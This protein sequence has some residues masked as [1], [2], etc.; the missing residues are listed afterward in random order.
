MSQ[1]LELAGAYARTEKGN[2]D[3]YYGGGDIGYV[4]AAAACA[5]VPLAIRPGK[6]IGIIEGNKVVEYIWH[7]S[8]VSNTGLVKKTADVDLTAI[9]NRIDAVEAGAPFGGMNPGNINDLNQIGLNKVGGIYRLDFGSTQIVNAPL[10]TYSLQV[11]QAGNSGRGLR[12]MAGYIY[13]QFFLQRA[14]TESGGW[15]PAVEIYHTGNLPAVIGPL[16]GAI[17]GRL[18][19][20]QVD[21]KIS[22]YDLLL[23]DGVPAEGNSMQKLYNAV[24]A[25]LVEKQFNTIALRNAYNVPRLPFQAFVS[26]DGDG[27]WAVYRATTTGV[28]ATYIKTSDPD[29]LNAAL[30]ASAIKAAYESNPDTYAFTN[31]L[32]TKLNA[33]AVGATANT[34]ATDA[35][36]QITAAVSEDNKHVTRLKLFNWWTWIKAQAATIGGVWNFTGGLKVNGADVL[37]TLSGDISTKLNNGDNTS[38][39]GDEGGIPLLSAAGKFIRNNYLKFVALTRELVIGAA[40]VPG[41][42]TIW[43]NVFKLYVQDNIGDGQAFLVINALQ[44]KA[45][46]IVDKANNV[47]MIFRTLASGAGVIISKLWIYDQGVVLPL[48]KGQASLNTTGATGAKF[49]GMMA[50]GNTQFSIPMD[51]DAMVCAVSFRLRLQNATG[52]IIIHYKY[53]GTFKRVGGLITA[54]GNPKTDILCDNGTSY[55]TAVPEQS[56]NNKLVLS[57]TQGAADNTVY[58]GG[59]YDINYQI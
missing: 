4:N 30:S 33:I 22:A 35:E 25:G 17:N 34:P 42:L 6:T 9:N 55:F 31:A 12:L 8:D 21:D 18:T 59:F 1:P 48:Y 15:Q 36:T 50:D 20:A 38:L 10:P 58:T 57:F 54:H 51:V 29:L 46:Q 41:K 11:M 3:Q 47:Y 2:N 40:G 13:D 19:G 44:D 43:S 5:F 7:P 56:G 45:F 37:T 24:I 52:S 16:Q 49:Y 32:L 27:K 26:D 28:N 14:A 53:E 39:A 23:K